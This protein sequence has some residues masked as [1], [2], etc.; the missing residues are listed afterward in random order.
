MQTKGGSPQILCLNCRYELTGFRVGDICPEC[1]TQIRELID[2]STIS[3]TK[4]MF[5]L[6]CGVLSVIA[7]LGTAVFFPFRLI[8][9]WQAVGISTG[10]VAVVYSINLRY[11]IRT[12]KMP[13]RAHRMLRAAR[14]L[15]W[16]GFV[17]SLALASLLIS[18]Y[19]LMYLIA[20]VA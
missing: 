8:L 11:A 15:G 20:G 4:S 6:A 7:T 5:A 18:G 19:V 17:L 13:I 14:I 3:N 16:I 9:W 1:G 10:F 12:G 2:Q